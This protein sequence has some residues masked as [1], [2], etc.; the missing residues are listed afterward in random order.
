MAEKKGVLLSH[1]PGE[2]AQGAADPATILVHPQSPGWDQNPQ[3]GF[4]ACLSPHC[5]HRA[6]SG[7]R[8]TPPPPPLRLGHSLRSHIAEVRVRIHSSPP[9]HRILSIHGWL[10][11]HPIT[12]GPQEDQYHHILH[13]G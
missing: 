1:L 4:Q 6:W 3:L 9:W 11:G 8:K 13:S 12:G 5:A 10:G 2:L 7:S